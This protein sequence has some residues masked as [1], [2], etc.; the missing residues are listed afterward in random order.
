MG[1]LATCALFMIAFGDDYNDLKYGFLD[2][3]RVSIAIALAGAALFFWSTTGLELGSSRFR[4]YL[5]LLVG[6]FE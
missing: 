5:W 4:L 2:V 6:C 1:L 3:G